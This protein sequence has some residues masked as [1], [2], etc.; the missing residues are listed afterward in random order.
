MKE[1][2]RKSG[3][4][5]HN[6]TYQSPVAPQRIVLKPILLCE[7][8]DTRSS[9]AR[10]S[11]DHSDKHGG[12]YTETRRGERD[13]RIQ[14]LPQSAVQEHDHISPEIDSPLRESS[15][16][17]ST[18]SRPKTKSRFRS[19]R[20]AVEGNDLQQRKHG[21]LQDLRDHF[22]HARHQLYDMLA[23]R[24]CILCMV[25]V[26]IWVTNAPIMLLPLALLGS[27]LAIMSP[28]AGSVTTLTPQSVSMTV[29]TSAKLLN[30][31]NSFEPMLRRHTRT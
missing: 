17:R 24:C 10:T 12:T 16:Q 22:Q 7:S 30:D 13:L 25:M 3:E 4:E 8:Q 11:F 5:L 19:V 1:V 15:E 26:G 29:T 6:K 20:S 18:T 31:Y 27:S 2:V 14:G 21:A 9:D 28:R 23:K